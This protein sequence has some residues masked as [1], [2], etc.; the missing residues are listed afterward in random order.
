MAPLSEEDG[1]DQDGEQFP[2]VPAALTNRPNS[3]PSI[4]LS[5]SIGSNTPSA[6]VVRASPTGT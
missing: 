3:P 4:E 6:V 5:R 2:T 1:D